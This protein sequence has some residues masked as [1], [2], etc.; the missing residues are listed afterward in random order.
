MDT[1]HA[2]VSSTRPSESLQDN[3]LTT[4]KPLLMDAITLN[5]TDGHHVNTNKVLIIGAGI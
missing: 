1:R 2:A 4:D 5:G 3:I